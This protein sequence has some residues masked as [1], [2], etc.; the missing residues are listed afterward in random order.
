M[1]EGPLETGSLLDGRYRIDAQ[2]GR[3]GMGVVYRGTDLTLRRP[4]A[5]KVLQARAAD[6]STLARFLGEAQTLAQVE[7]RGLVPIYAVGRTGDFYYMVMKLLEGRTLAEVLKAGPLPPAEVGRVLVAVCDAL[8][9]LHQAGLVHRDVKPANIMI[10]PDGRVTVMDLGIATASGMNEA[11]LLAVGTPRYMAPEMLGTSEVDGRADVYSLGIIGYHAL[12]GA[13]P[14]DGPTPMA[15]LFKH[16]H[17]ALEPVRKRAPQVP[18]ALAHA[19][20]V[21]LEK[22]PVRRYPTAQHFAVAI[23]EAL[24]PKGSTG[25]WVAVGALVGMAGAMAV[26]LMQGPDPVVVAD[27]AAP[28]PKFLRFDAEV[29]LDAA[30]VQE[31]DAM[32]LEAE[33]AGRRKPLRP[34]RPPAPGT[35]APGTDAPGTDAPGTEAPLAPGTEGPRAP[36]TE[37]PRAPVT[38][39]PGQVRVRITSTPP[40]ATVKEGGAVLGTTPFVLERPVSGRSVVLTLSKAGY[41][42]ATTR[43]SLSKDGVVRVSLESAFELVP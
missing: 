12:T 29:P 7:H 27:A 18:K 28:K 10:G 15:V 40:G 9:A 39:A 30:R 37:G 42:P 6:D 36:R 38:A 3:G 19:I 17:E 11:S 25:F 20:E 8:G 24:Q 33:D 32:V 14:F 21:A 1:S 26:W 4:V 31:A 5:I 16:A 23:Q 2:V 35:E 13:V 34:N 41:E 43:V 22:Q